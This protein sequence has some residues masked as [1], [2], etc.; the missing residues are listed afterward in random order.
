MKALGVSRTGGTLRAKGGLVLVPLST[1]G[2]H[3]DGKDFWIL[4]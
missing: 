1:G 2:T 4:T 3:F